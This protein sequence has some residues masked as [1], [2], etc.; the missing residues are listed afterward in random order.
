MRTIHHPEVVIPAYDEEVYTYDELPQEAKDKAFE[1]WVESGA[2][3][4]QYNFACEDIGEC[5]N[6]FCKATGAEWR[7]DSYDIVYV[8]APSST[9]GT[10]PESVRADSPLKD[11][12]FC[13]SMDICDAWNAHFPRIGE[14]YAAYMDSDQYTDEA[15]EAEKAYSVE[16][17]AALEDV[18]KAAR[19][20]TEAEWDYWIYN[21]RTA[22]EDFKADANEYD[23]E[24]NIVA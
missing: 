1:E 15:Y 16:V 12:G 22:F 19:K 18:E 5:L 2:N 9:W 7:F 21:D 4:D 8:E 13:Y 20:L 17:L 11:N 3:R 6:D 23:L 24:G 14:L 10:Y